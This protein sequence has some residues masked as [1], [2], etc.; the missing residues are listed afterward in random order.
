MK[1]IALAEGISAIIDDEDFD[2]VMEHKWRCDFKSKTHGSY[3]CTI[4][5]RKNSIYMHRFITRA[6]KGMVVDHKNGDGL[7]NRK[8][9][10]RV[11]T[12]QENSRSRQ[13]LQKNNTSGYQ[14]VF[15][16]QYGWQARIRINGE[17]TYLGFSKNKVLMAKLYDEAAKKYHRDFATL[18]FK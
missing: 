15:K 16:S 10:L 4:G 9:N 17:D 1:K 6:P 11:C 5:I 12:H 18:N 7:D 14:G 3:A 2:R 8:G 13:C